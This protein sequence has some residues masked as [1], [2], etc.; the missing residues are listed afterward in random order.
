ME[1][2]S[3]HSPTRFEFGKGTEAKAGQLCKL[4]GATKVLVHFGGGSAVKSGL[5]KRVTGSL[6][7]EGLAYVTLGGVQPNPRSGLVYQG[8]D[9]ARKE[10]VDFILAVGGGSVIDSA[11]AIAFGTLYEGDFWD[12]H[13]PKTPVPKALPVGTVLTIP[14]AGSE[15]SYNCVITKEETLKKRGTNGECLRPKFSIMNPELCATLPAYQTASG[16][17][18]IMAHVLERYFSPTE[19]VEI[20]DR[21]CEALLLTVV[22]EAPKLI[23]NPADY[24]A[25]AN[26]MWA[27]MLAHNNSC[28]VGRVQDWTSHGLEHE[29]SALYD[30]AHGAGLAVIFP[31]WMEYVLKKGVDKLAQLANRVF[32]IELDKANP[33]S[34]AKEGIKA[35]RE[36]FKELGLPTTLREIGAKEEDLPFMAGN[37]D[38]RPDGTYGGFVKITKEDAE[39]IF[40][41]AW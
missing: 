4:Y 38:Y 27:G 28:G 17:A 25:R 3:F 13:E 31:A 23:K 12:F 40:R 9:L 24:Q 34:T 8:I 14:A 6:E 7:S 10:G 5:L 36:F 37:L 18:D 2:F 35:L 11:K 20:T 32:G 30:V 15:G 21:L 29:L 33:Q 16:V 19:D 22:K 26:V 1:N 39:N 41:L